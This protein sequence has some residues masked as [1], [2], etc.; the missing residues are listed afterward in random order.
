MPYECR[1]CGG[2]YCASH[3][4]PENHGCAGLDAYEADVQSRGKI[5]D[6]RATRRTGDSGTMERLLGSVPLGA[7][8]GNVT[9]L[10]L[11]IMVVVWL[12]QHVVLFLLPLPTAEARSLHNALFV[13]D[14]AHVEYVWTWVTSVFS[15]APVNFGHIFINGLVLYFFG[16]FAERRIGSKRYAMLFVGAGVVAGL[17]Q[18]LVA[19]GS[20][21]P[22]RVLGASGGVM[23]IMGLLTV[24]NPNLT[25]YFWFVL[26]MPLWVLTIGF[27][28][29]DLFF[30]SAGGAGAGGVARLAHLSGLALGLAYG[31]KLKREGLDVRDRLQF[32]G[33]GGGRRGP[34][35]I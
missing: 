19:T 15:H 29:Y 11:A 24:L 28:L 1:F 27:A 23:A 2:T 20:A 26:P 10:F 13:L 6:D 7:F 18:V 34:P 25:V 16:T 17:A 35:R 31:W 12:L 5:Y 30:L 22:A 3:R 8:R 21:E 33:G 9:Y 32:G 4:L 14:S